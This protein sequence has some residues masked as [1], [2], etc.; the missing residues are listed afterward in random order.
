MQGFVILSAKNP[1]F[2]GGKW[3]ILR[4]KY[5][6]RADSMTLYGLKN[7]D[8]CRK[9]IKEIRATGAD[10]TLIDVRID[11]VSM[12]DLIRFQTTFGD[13]LLN[14]RSTTWRG[15]SE[16]ERGMPSL[17]LLTTHPA[18]MKRPVIDGPNGLT[19]GWAKEVSAQYL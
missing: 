4:H 7:C 1:L 8:T 15:L 6:E 18:L 9:A 16:T 12:D 14:T 10:V 19:L 2:R 17:E 5:N 13:A 11:G 3:F